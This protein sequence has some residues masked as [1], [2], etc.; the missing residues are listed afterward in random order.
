[1]RRGP[2]A[3][4]RDATG[5][6]QNS[7]GTAAAER[8]RRADLRSGLNAQRQTNQ[9]R[10]VV[11]DRFRAQAGKA[12]QALSG[13]DPDQKSQP[14]QAAEAGRALTSEERANA[15]KDVREQLD[16]QDREAKSDKYGWIRQRQQRGKDRGGGGRGR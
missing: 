4:G 1:R 11:P 12:M 10:G 6:M 7:A 13:M 2:S 8:G 3:P 5:T 14:R 16:R 15:R 9:L